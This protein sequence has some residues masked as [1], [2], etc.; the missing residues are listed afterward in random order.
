MR[1]LIYTS[2]GFI[3]VASNFHTLGAIFLIIA[4]LVLMLDNTPESTPQLR[5]VEKTLK[6]GSLYYEAHVKKSP[7]SM[8]YVEREGYTLRWVELAGKQELDRLI[9]IKKAVDNRVAVSQ[10]IL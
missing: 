10:K 2:I 6:D 3:L 8:W 1:F 9:K 7:L 5:I 4:L